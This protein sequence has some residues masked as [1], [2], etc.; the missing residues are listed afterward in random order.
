MN[1]DLNT[2]VVGHG[3]FRQIC[4]KREVAAPIQRVWDALT[5]DQQIKHW[6]AAGVIEPREGGRYH[7]GGMEDDNCNEDNSNEDAGPG[8][9]GI[10]K[11]F[12]PPYVLEYTWHGEYPDA[13]IVRFDL[14]SLSANSTLVTLTQNVPAA[15]AVPAAAG[16]YEIVEHLQ[17]YAETEAPVTK[18]PERFDKLQ[19]QFVAVGLTG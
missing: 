11:V 1:K 10:I 4:V 16:W 5:D 19:E 8:L 12:V 3:D 6:W 18:D 7:L 2:S 17:I 13:G 14:M 15:H 9:D